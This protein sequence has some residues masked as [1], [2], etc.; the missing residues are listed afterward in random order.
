MTLHDSNGWHEANPLDTHSAG[1]VGT[2]TVRPTLEGARMARL[3][4]EPS[5]A[6]RTPTGLRELVTSSGPAD[7]ILFVTKQPVG[8][9]E[10]KK[11]GPHRHPCD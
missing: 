10:A 8:A 3:S 9:I 7:Y 6:S 2:R 4:L 1:D 11:V 5:T